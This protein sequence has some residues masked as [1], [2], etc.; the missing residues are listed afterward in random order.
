MLFV[1]QV[2]FVDGTTYSVLLRY[3]LVPFIL[4]Y[5]VCLLP[6]LGLKEEE[7]ASNSREARK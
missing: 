7:K 3:V 2:F 5:A 6:P 4:N 1:S